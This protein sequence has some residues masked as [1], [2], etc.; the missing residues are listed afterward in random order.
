MENEKNF[1]PIRDAEIFTGLKQQTLRKLY[2]E[3]ILKGY[4]TK[5]GQ[6]LFSKES[7][8]E[9]CKI[10]CNS[11]K[12]INE[13]TNILYARVSSKKQCDDL[14]RQ[15][16]FIKSAKPEYINYRVVT[17]TASGINFK[18]KGLLEILERSMQGVIGEVVVAHRDR[19]SRFGFDLIKIIIEKAGGKLTVIDDNKEKSSEQELAEDLLSIVHIY[20]CRQMGKRSYKGRKNKNINDS[21]KIKKG[22]KDINR[23]ESSS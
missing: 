8:C 10:S 7:L 1:L 15:I 4:K 23:Q 9:F 14:D 12:T 22:S 11:K 5:S 17:D 13:K 6:R 20:S 18:R 16:E 21:I 2:E 3:N 19:M